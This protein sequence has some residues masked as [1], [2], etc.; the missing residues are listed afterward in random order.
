MDGWHKTA[1]VL[2]AQNCGLEALVEAGRMIKVRPDR[3]NPRSRGY[4]C[5]KGLNVLYHQYPKD[6]LTEP[7]KRVGGRFEPISWDQAID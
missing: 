7:L 6:R 3:E 5:R 4:A 2:C 1:C